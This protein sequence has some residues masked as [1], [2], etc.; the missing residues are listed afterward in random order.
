MTVSMFERSSMWK[1]RLFVGSR[2]KGELAEEN[3]RSLCEE[4][5][6]GEYEI[7]VIDLS[8]DPALASRHQILALPTLVRS[9]PTPPR[10]IIGDLSSPDVLRAALGL[11]E[12]KR[13]LLPTIE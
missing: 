11:P 9:E 2:S 10:K 13:S 4:S 1:F 8:K 7:E 6:P 12:G 5:I 3:L